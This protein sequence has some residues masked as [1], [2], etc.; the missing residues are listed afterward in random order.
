MV[1]IHPAVPVKALKAFEF[2]DQSHSLFVL[3]RVDF[4]HKAAGKLNHR[5]SATGHTVRLNHNAR[6]GCFCLRKGIGKIVDV[7]R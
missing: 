7:V 1:R 5:C 3:I 4:S 6:S 2:S